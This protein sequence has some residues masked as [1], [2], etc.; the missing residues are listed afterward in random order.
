MTKLGGVF[1][2]F[3][4]KVS[5]FFYP[6]TD[7]LLVKYHPRQE[8]NAGD[9]RRKYSHHVRGQQDPQRMDVH[10]IRCDPKKTEQTAS[11]QK[12]TT[13]ES[14]VS[15]TSQAFRY[16]FHRICTFCSRYSAQKVDGEIQHRPIR[17]KPCCKEWRVVGKYE[18]EKNSTLFGILVVTFFYFSNFLNFNTEVHG[19]PIFFNVLL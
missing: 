11:R 9:V 6:Y 12:T 13:R 19:A 15:E 4:I 8:I 16:Y 14:L 1:L 18:L 17:T 2:I 7:E 5:V 3:R 10:V